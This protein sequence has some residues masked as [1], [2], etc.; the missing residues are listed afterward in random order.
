MPTDGSYTGVYGWSPAAPVDSATIG[1]G[2][3]GQ[4]DDWGVY[5]SGTVGVYGFGTFGVIGESGSVNAGVL[6]LG[7]SATDLALDVR[8]KVKFSRSGVA[9]VTAGNS[10]RVVTFAGVTANSQV[11]AVMKTNRSN[12][13]VRAVV[14]AAGKFTIYLNASVTATTYVSFFIL[15]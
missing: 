8:G 6:A 15:D 9:G 10:T 11:M 12:R 13:W 7:A 4:S 1:V 2:V 3:V 5:G 14:P